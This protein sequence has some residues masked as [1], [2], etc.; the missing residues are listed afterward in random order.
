MSGSDSDDIF[1]TQ[2]TFKSEASDDNVSYDTVCAADGA[3]FLLMI[4]DKTLGENEEADTQPLL[5]NDQPLQC[6]YSDISDVEITADRPGHARF[7]RS[8]RR[9]ERGL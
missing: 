4:G 7:S 3:D 2:S 8:K 6:D 9:A 1:I 5:G